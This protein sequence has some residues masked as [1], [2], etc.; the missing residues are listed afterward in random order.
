MNQKIKTGLGTIIILI[1]AL[2]TG[3]FIWQYEKNQLPDER[4]ISQPPRNN[5]TQPVFC[6]QDAK[7]CSNG[8][9]VS[10][11]GP[12][13]EFAPCSNAQIIG[14]PCEYAKI[15]GT[16]IILAIAQDNTAKFT[17]TATSKLPTS[18]LA[19]NLNGEHLDTLNILDSQN[20]S[21]NIGDKINCEASIET[22]GT[23]TPVIFR[24]TK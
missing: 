17:F 23:C 21:L 14:G 1:I 6:A 3:A 12:N 2:T 22:K 11:T 24:F 13:C 10:R 16:C 18:G 19:K 4:Q 15:P 7:R 8:S 9:Y 5:K 20:L